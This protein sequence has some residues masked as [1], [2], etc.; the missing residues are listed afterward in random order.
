[1]RLARFRDTRARPTFLA[2]LALLPAR[3]GVAQDPEPR[4]EPMA[5]A[6]LH[7]TSKV[8]GDLQPFAACAT[9]LS[10]DPKPLIVDLIPG[11]L[12]NLEGAARG[13]RQICEI[14]REAGLSCVALRPCGRGNGSLYQGCGEVDVYESI[15]AL[16]AR[17]A[18]DPD[19]ISV[20]GAS[21]GGA[22]TWY[23]ASHFPDFWAAAAPF[24]GYCDHRLWEKPG[25]S[26][27]P[28]QAWED[29]SWTSR[30]AA[31]RAGNLRHTALRIAHGEWDRAVGGGVPVEQSRQMDRKLTE[32]GIPHVYIEIPKTGHNA[33]REALWKET[34]P[35]LLRQKRVKEPDRVTLTVHTLRHNRSHWVEVE[36]Q[37]ASG[38]PSWVEASVERAGKKARAITSNV[39]RLVLGPIRGGSSLDLEIDGSTLRGI[40]LTAPQRF[41]SAVDGSWS[42]TGGAIPAAE[43][44]PGLSGP[45][46][47]IFIAPTLIIYGDSG[48]EA[49]SEFNRSMA[50]NAAQL[51]SQTNGGLHRGGIQGDNAVL[52][53]VITDKQALDVMQ[54]R[55]ASAPALAKG[56]TVSA[57]LLSR[58]NLFFVG[59]VSSN[60]ALARIAGALPIAFSEKKLAL[61][62]RT[63]QGD[64][65]ALYAVFPHPDGRRYAAILAGGEPDAISW[66][67]HVGLQLLPDYLVFDHDRVVD[68]GFWSNGWRAA[69]LQDRNG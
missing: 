8:Y 48:S 26:T 4:L 52:L 55:A 57:E 43:K 27:F 39:R 31:Y 6:I 47:D 61:A 9:D 12:G 33:R 64:H 16:R 3:A 44:R 60:A 32:A 37:A 56:V 40:D 15:E 59:G 69:E 45:F 30:G 58:S 18:I 28:L 53:P 68:W 23:H 46:G 5:P 67:S 25:G 22:A 42:R 65:L 63:Y 54:S 35:W 7:Y 51:F 24:C 50:V 49:E 19:R 11:T 17:V 14:A 10:P 66:G 13:C 34:V 20:T 38:K 62:G 21:M 1:M 36:Q 41:Q 2:V 29:F